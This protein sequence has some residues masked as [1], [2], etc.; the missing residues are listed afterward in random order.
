MIFLPVFGAD[1]HD[2]AAVAAMHRHCL[3][4]QG[5]AII[6]ALFAA[7]A[8]PAL[9]VVNG[10]GVISGAAQA[11]RFSSVMMLATGAGQTALPS[12]WTASRW[13]SGSW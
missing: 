13:L 12:R 11:A 4:W 7:F 6:Q 5:A 3:E 9:W 1:H 8:A 2:V 10:H